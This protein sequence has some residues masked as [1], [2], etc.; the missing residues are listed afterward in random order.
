MLRKV[1]NVRILE[2]PVYERKR[3]GKGLFFDKYEE[4][5]KIESWTVSFSTKGSFFEL[6]GEEH[7]R[8]VMESRGCLRIGC[9]DGRTL[10]WTPIGFYSADSDLPD[11]EVELLLGSFRL[12]CG[13][14]AREVTTPET[15]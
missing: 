4:T 1:S 8:K 2:L 12:S 7:P 11:E 15:Q 13:W 5:N 14:S 6:T 3:I 10:W 9:E